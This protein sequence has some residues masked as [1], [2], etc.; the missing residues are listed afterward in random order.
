MKKSPFFLGFYNKSKESLKPSAIINLK[1]ELMN[2]TGN[3]E[4][5]WSG[6]RAIPAA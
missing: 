1:L 6:A 4:M 3:A 5:N 2:E